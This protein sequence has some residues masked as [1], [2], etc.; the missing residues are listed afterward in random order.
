MGMGGLQSRRRGAG[1]SDGQR[2]DR[3]DE[4][5]SEGGAS[6]RR[7]FYG[8]R[9]S[10]A[11]SGIRLAEAVTAGYEGGALDGVCGRAKGKSVASKRRHSIL[12]SSPSLISDGFLQ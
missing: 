4:L 3:E 10:G 9:F 11:S 7:G 6:L 12:A 5:R 1:Q 2:H 8:G